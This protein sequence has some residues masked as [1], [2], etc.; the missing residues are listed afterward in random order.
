MKKFRPLAVAVIGIL[1]VA[2]VF[3]PV[4]GHTLALETLQDFA[5][6]PIFGCVALLVLLL[7]RDHARLAAAPVWVQYLLAFAATVVLGGLSELAQIP[8]ARDASW[9]DLRSDAVGAAAFLGIFAALD[10]R[11]HKVV[12]PACV[13][14]GVALLAIHATPLATATTEYLRRDREFPVLLDF[15]QQLDSYF[16]VPQWAHL[17]LHSMPPRWAQRPGESTLRVRFDTGPWPGIDFTEPGPDWREYRDLALDITNP[18]DSEL[19][20]VLRVHDVHHNFQYADRF[21]RTLRVPAQTRSVLRVPIADIQ[22]APA[23]RP[24]DLTQIADFMLFRASEVTT[25]EMWISRAW[26]E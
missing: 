17:D 16:L 4:P 1:L 7:I 14:I 21:N 18:T 22:S 13:L 11:L 3:T 10:R 15:T 5:H 26:L 25:A 20:V 6:G 2:V 12:R 19:L 8:I 9:F 24:M 23:G